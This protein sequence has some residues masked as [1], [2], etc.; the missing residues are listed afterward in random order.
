M[1]T[2]MIFLYCLS[3]FYFSKI[4]K[5]QNTDFIIF[6]QQLRGQIDLD[7]KTMMMKDLNLFYSMNDFN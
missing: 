3:K 6:L 2:L 1:C 7:T 4:C 5:G